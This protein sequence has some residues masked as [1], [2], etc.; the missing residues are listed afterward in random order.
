MKEEQVEL[1]EL[2]E[3]RKCLLHAIRQLFE[4]DCELALDTLKAGGFQE[5]EYIVY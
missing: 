3:D 2:R 5:D 4:G 1:E